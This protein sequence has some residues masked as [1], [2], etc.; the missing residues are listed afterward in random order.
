MGW[1][2]K[3]KWKDYYDFVSPQSYYQT[4]LC[5]VFRK[6]ALFHQDASGSNQSSTFLPDYVNSLS[7]SI[8]RI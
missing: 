2:E 4:T 5:S 6:D 7:S 3:S 1:F 8:I